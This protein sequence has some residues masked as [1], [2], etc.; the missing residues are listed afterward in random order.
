[1]Y[2]RRKNELK[3]DGIFIFG[4]LIKDAKY[5]PVVE[6]TIE[7]S[8]VGRLARIIIYRKETLIDCNDQS[9][10]AGDLNK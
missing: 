9:I 8:E 7:K 2:K 4:I 6:L 10:G 5:K 3:E 1:M